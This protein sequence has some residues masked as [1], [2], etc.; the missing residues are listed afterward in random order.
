MLFVLLCWCFFVIHSLSE[1]FFVGRKAT[2]TDNNTNTHRDSSSQTPAHTDTHGPTDRQTHRHTHTHGPTDRQTDRHTHTRTDRHTHTQAHTHTHTRLTQT[3]ELTVRYYNKQCWCHIADAPHPLQ[4]IARADD[5][6]RTR[7]PVQIR[8]HGESCV[9]PQSVSCHR[10]HLTARSDHSAPFRTALFLRHELRGLCLRVVL[11]PSPWTHRHRHRHT[12][13]HTDTHT[14]THIHTHT[15]THTTL[16]HTHTHTYTHTHLRKS[17]KS[18]TTH[19]SYLLTEYIIDSHLKI[20]SKLFYFRYYF[21]S[22]YLSTGCE[23]TLM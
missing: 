17:N 13:T 15:Y 2:G 16:R 6:Q 21:G 3:A 9:S 1:L 14:H 22:C 10:R 4:S 20:K 18:N 7:P 11:V 5:Q 19:E 23:L 8:R 12:H